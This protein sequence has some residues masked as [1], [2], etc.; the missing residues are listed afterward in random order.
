QPGAVFQ[1]LGQ[2][3]SELTE[4]LKEDDITFA[5]AIQHIDRLIAEAEKLEAIA[6][7]FQE[8]VETVSGG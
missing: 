3:H 6:R 5:E 8:A 7:E 1:Q 2:A 4:A